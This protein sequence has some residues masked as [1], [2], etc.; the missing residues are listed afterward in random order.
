MKRVHVFGLIAGLLLVANLW[1]RMGGSQSEF[2]WTQDGVA[3]DVPRGS[4]LLDKM[5]RHPT[6]QFSTK[7]DSAAAEASPRNPFE[8][9]IDARLEAERAQQ[10]EAMRIQAEIPTIESDPVPEVEPEPEFDGTILG[11]FEDTY[12]Q[13]MRVALKYDDVVYV[14]SAGDRIEDIYEIRSIDTEQVIVR[15][16]AQ[17]HDIRIPY[18]EESNVRW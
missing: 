16:L 12:A 18:A 7:S 3:L 8:Y 2:G 17:A 10:L 6:L 11:V 1:S 5:E 15:H 13:R 14:L 4:R 9:G